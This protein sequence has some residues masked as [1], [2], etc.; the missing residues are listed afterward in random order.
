MNDFQIPATHAVDPVDRILSEVADERDRQDAKWGE[1][2]HADGTGPDV[3]WVIGQ[4]R[5]AWIA[6]DAIRKWCDAAHQRGDGSWLNILHEEVAEAFAAPDTAALRAE[7]IQVAAVAAAWV[8]AIDRR[9][10]AA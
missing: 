2:N 5:P 8:E 3:R 9:G 10:G 7:L 6:A 4:N 1:Q